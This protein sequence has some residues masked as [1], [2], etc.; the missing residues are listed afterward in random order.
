MM[1]N[2]DAETAIGAEMRMSFIRRTVL[3]F[4]V[5]IAV[6]LLN[7][8]FSYRAT[9][10]LVESEKW[11]AHTYTVLS[12]IDELEYSVQESQTSADDFVITGKPEKLTAFREYLSTAEA[13]VGLLRQLTAD[14]PTQQRLLSEVEPKLV[15]LGQFLDAAVR[16]REQSRAAEP[17]T[18]EKAQA[19]TQ[20]IGKLKDQEAELLRARSARVAVN[21]RTARGGLLVGSLATLF[22]LLTVAYLIVTGEKQRS[23]AQESRLNLATIVDSSED[24]ILSKTLG[25]KLLS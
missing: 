2:A 19:V 9:S 22:L 13:K 7:V 8:Y 6:L 16:S 18:G 23:A 1:W 17:P 15:D 3:L 12:A 20:K 5:L 11:L 14:N 25:G 4:S 10:Q 24:A 21:L